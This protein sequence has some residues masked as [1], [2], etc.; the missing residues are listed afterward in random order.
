M[1][2]IYAYE[3][4]PRC[5]QSYLTCIANE[6][7]HFAAERGTR[8]NLTKKCLEIIINFLQFKPSP[9]NEL[10]LMGTVIKR[11]SSYKILGYTLAMT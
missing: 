9:T 3:V 11:V 8:L 10:Q 7:H 6:I 4:I 1:D 5:S 2:D